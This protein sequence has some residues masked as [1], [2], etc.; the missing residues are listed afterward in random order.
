MRNRAA[1]TRR[2]LAA[3][4]AVLAMAWPSIGAALEQWPTGLPAGAY[5]LDAARSTVT[6]RIRFRS[7]TRHTVTFSR[8]DG[9][10]DYSPQ[11][12]STT[13]VTIRVDPNSLSEPGSI[14]GRTTL[15]MLQ[16]SRFQT[17]LFVSRGLVAEKE[18]IWLLG[19]L[20][21]HGVTRPVRFALT[22]DGMAPAAG[23]EPRLAFR[24][25]GQI[26]RSEFGMSSMRALVS[27]RVDLLFNVEFRPR[28]PLD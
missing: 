26:R 8:V 5:G 27:D 17:I 24:G 2:G 28:P 25:A 22:F 10:V 9:A 13:R 3:A 19:D 23:N 7:L 4:A 18:H 16:P 1:R 21:L 20:T 6:A 14:V 12:W 11:H 15:K